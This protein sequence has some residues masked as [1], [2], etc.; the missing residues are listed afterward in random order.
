MGSA[1]FNVIGQQFVP[2]PVQPFWKA[3]AAGVVWAAV[4]FFLFVSWTSS[5]AWSEIHRFAAAFGATLACMATPYLTVASWPRFDVVGKVVL[6]VI[7]LVG[8]FVLA[9]K[10]WARTKLKQL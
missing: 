2:H 6:D 3:I 7:A 1:W 4:A 10:V 8:F 5:P 9:R